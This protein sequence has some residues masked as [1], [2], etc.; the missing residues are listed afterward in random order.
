M[1]GELISN[2][3]ELR[4]QAGLSQTDLAYIIGVSPDTVANW[5][6]GRRGLESIE[7]FVRL[8]QCLRCDPTDLIEYKD[9]NDESDLKDEI[10]F[11]KTRIERRKN[12]KKKS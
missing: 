11:L 4:E 3:K 2:I 5:E 8:C 12:S 10:N 9:N 1:M 7:R 6:S